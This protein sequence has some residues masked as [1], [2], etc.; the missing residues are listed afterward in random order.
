MC[1]TAPD[2]WTFADEIEYVFRVPMFFLYVFSSYASISSWFVYLSLLSTH[3]STHEDLYHFRK[4]SVD[5]SLFGGTYVRN[6]WKRRVSWTPM[7]PPISLPGIMW[8][9]SGHILKRS[10]CPLIHSWTWHT[11]TEGCA[12]PP[13][14]RNVPPLSTLTRPSN[15]FRSSLFEFRQSKSSKIWVLLFYNMPPP[16]WMLVNLN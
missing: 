1:Q 6:H 7:L 8:I 14:H 3:P 10:H 12:Q 9:G 13:E 2:G 16:P 15:C 5:N 4:P 11:L